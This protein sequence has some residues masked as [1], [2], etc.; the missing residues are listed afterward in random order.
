MERMSW[1]DWFNTVISCG[2][3]SMAFLRELIE[4]DP[5]IEVRWRASVVRNIEE[6]G[7]AE[8]FDRSV[9]NRDALEAN[10]NRAGWFVFDKRA[11]DERAH[12]E[13]VGRRADKV[14][15]EYEQ[16]LD[17]VAEAKARR[18]MERREVADEVARRKAE[19]DARRRNHAAPARKFRV[20][21]HRG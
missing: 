21:R 15:R 4:E 8:G 18:A 12:R 1:K 3:A 20:V 5:S 16:V 14:V 11:A 9:L 17:R 2:F 19:I 10:L 13:K 6:H 7:H